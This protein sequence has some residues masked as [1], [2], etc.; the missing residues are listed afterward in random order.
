M[1]TKNILLIFVKNPEKGRVKTRLAQD[2]G[3]EKAL[4]AYEKLLHYTRKI[5]YS[6]KTEAIRQVWYSRFVPD[7][8]HWFKGKFEK[9]VQQGETLGERMRLAFEK[10]FA[11]GFDK[12]VIIGSDC[13]QLT[14]DILDKAYQELGVSD[15]VIGP[16]EDGG[17]YLLGMKDFHPELFDNINWSTQRVYEQTQSRIIQSGLTL[18]TLPVLNDVDTIED[19]NEVKEQFKVE[20]RE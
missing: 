3:D 20:G 9:K 16:S 15:V 10:A 5:I 1:H 11:S 12:A 7:D 2:I 17:Y 13:A 8:D 6:M 18:S 14:G 19:W 4:T